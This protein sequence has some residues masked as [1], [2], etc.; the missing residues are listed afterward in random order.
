MFINESNEMVAYDSSDAE[1]VG[2]VPERTEEEIVDAQEEGT[3]PE[4]PDTGG[5]GEE[6]PDDGD[7]GD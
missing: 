3:D 7:G 6:L 2:E 4:V 1:P 5:D